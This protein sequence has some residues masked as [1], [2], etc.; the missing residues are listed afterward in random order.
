MSEK[1]LTFC[2][3][4]TA[5]CGLVVELE[6]DR[7]VGVRGD[8]DHP[9]SAGYTCSK[10]RAIG[11]HHHAPNRLDHPLM[12]GRRVSWDDLLDDLAPRLAG[13]VSTQGPDSVGLYAANGGV[14]DKGSGLLVR[15]IFD[16]IGTRQRY[17]GATIDVAPAWF[18]AELVTGFALEVMPVWDPE[19][20]SPSL[21]IM[22]GQNPVVS[23]GYLNVL[24]DPVRRI[25]DYR[26]R[27][28]QLWVVDPRRSETAALADHHLAPLPGTDGLIL[29][30]LVRELLDRG[31]DRAEL[32]A[33]TDPAD[34]E[35]LRRALVPFSREVVAERCDV[36]AEE[37]D[38]LLSDVRRAGKVACP[39]GTGVTFSRQPVV[40]AWLRWAL[41]VVTG[42][43]DVPGGMRC[44]TGYFSP[45]DRRTS[46][47]AAPPDGR[48]EAGPPSRP[49]L[50][51]WL[52][53]YPCSAMVDEIEA[54][55]LRALVVHGGNPLAAFP[56]TERTL[57]AMQSLEV[58]A[59]V[60]VVANE[61]TEIATHIL[62]VG[63]M[64][65]RPD[66]SLR[67]RA[68]YTPA[69][70]ALG[71]DRRPAWWAYGSLAVRMG[72]DVLEGR[73]PDECDDEVLLRML[74][75]GAP[76]RFE[77][78]KAAGPRGVSDL[79]PVGWVRE[80]VLPDGRWRLAPQ[81]AIDRL[82]ALL[83]PRRAG[84]LTFVNRRQR[85]H[86]N[87]ARYLRP[88]DAEAEHPDVL[89]H[90][91]DAAGLGIADGQRIVLSNDT[92]SLEGTAR[93]GTGIRRGVVS[94]PHGWADT[95]VNQLISRTVDVDDLTGQPRISSVEVV[96]RAAASW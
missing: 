78:V 52:G 1:H 63:S 53:E 18:A 10:G 24:T 15:R 70:L 35:R 82:P 91:E 8:D 72:M 65:E 41:L 36:R 28:G 69:L 30:W 40:T 49:E 74:A 11:A 67:E 83:A 55:R 66:L 25:R 60:D 81:A 17:S 39:I 48:L 4:C 16:Q 58:L 57:K 13:L 29:A 59:V 19:A 85:R 95:N 76:D 88:E 38:A 42:S 84:T 26:R 54:G 87:S 62:S 96:V 77:T 50:P 37:L 46:W 3:I 27:G 9:E 92:G 94:V 2:R 75:A 12:H 34:V 90:A 33:W 44:S 23:H 14:S 79:P 93:V 51:R 45:P 86:V 7:V 20:D 32:D 21:T 73:S 43:I 6:G 68:C 89:L 56:E 5:F 22:V 64:L 31:A 61:L 80:R 47:D 71:G